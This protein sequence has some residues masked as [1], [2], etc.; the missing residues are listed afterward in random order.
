MKEIQEWIIDFYKQRGWIYPAS[1][2][3]NFLV[4]ELGELSKAIRTLEIGRDG[5]PEDQNK[6]EATI[7]DE[8]EQEIG[9]VL[10]N[11]MLIADMFN[12]DMMGALKKHIEKL[13]KRFKESSN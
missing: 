2:R 13:E 11:L 10:V 3:L 4:E 7:R 9:D 8:I 12:I 6:D 5:H 1:I